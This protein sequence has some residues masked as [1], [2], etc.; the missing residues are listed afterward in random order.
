MSHGAPDARLSNYRLERLLGSGGMG[1]VYLARDLA[2][3]RDVAIKFIAADKASDTSARHRLLREAKAAASLE[4]PNICGVHEVIVEPD[5]RTAIV[6]QYVEGETLAEVL[7]RGPLEPRFAVSIAMDLAK[8]LS[9]AHKRGIIH[10]DLKPQNVIITPERQAKLLDFG[11]ARQHEIADHSAETT[12]MLTTPGVVVGTPAYMSPEQ[13][14]QLP[15]DGRSDLFA[16]GAVL[17]ECLTG[18]RPFVGRSPIDVLA[19]VLQHH[20]PTVST[21]RPELTEQHDE[22]CRRLLAKHPDDRFKSAD[23][24]FGA[25]RVLSPDTSRTG[26]STDAEREQLLSRQVKAPRTLVVAAMGALVLVAAFAVWRWGLPEISTTAEAADWY[27]RGTEAIRDGSY[28][29]GRLRLQEA[30]RLDAAYAPAYV[31]LAEAE[32]E[33]DESE[34]AVQALLKVTRLTPSDS[35]LPLDERFRFRAVRALAQRDVDEAVKAYQELVERRPRDAGAWLDLGRAQDAAALSGDARASYEKAIQIDAQYA[36][37][38][39]RRGIILALE[40]QRD[41]ALDAFAN[42]ERLYHAASSVEGEIETLIRRGGFLNGIG[43]LRDARAALERAIDLAGGTLQSRAQTIRAQLQLSSVTASEGRW[44]E[45]EKMAALAVDSALRERLDTVA[46]DGLI[47]LGNVLIHKNK[48]AEADPH[49]LRAIKIA[50]ERKAQRI[51]ARAKL[52]R[53]ALMVQVGRTNDGLATARETLDYFQANR[54]RRYE[55]QVLSI[56]ARAH[57]GLGQ[58]PEARALAERALLVSGEI[59]DEARAAE[60]LD[61]LAGQTNAMGAL[62]DALQF[63]ARALEIHTRLNDLATLPYD[64]VNRADLLIRVGRHAEGAQLLD[65]IDAGIAKKL[66]A[67]LLHG[68]RARLL[69]ALSA[70]IQHRPETS[71]RLARGFPPTEDGKAD[72]RSELAALLL[73]YSKAPPASRS[74]RLPDAPL[75]GKVL[76]TTGRE[77]RYW[78]LAARL[79]RNDVRGALTGADETL[80]SNG[81]TV[82]YEF[83]WRVAAIGAAA[84]RA[85]RDVERQRV[86]TE[87]AQRALQRLRKEWKSDVASYDARPDLVELRRKAGLD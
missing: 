81:A 85:M 20:P 74:G 86:F 19:A 38:H 35:R 11:V 70:A 5:G 56:M 7:R 84:A 41:A 31:R 61:N 67:Y 63:R 22:L 48:L 1:S 15:I 69:R 47:D 16:L 77:L 39:L 13:A 78:D 24:L 46:A 42:A 73:Q 10:R 30:I 51:V 64:L 71:S 82:S 75:A 36:A 18:R 50:G 43:E 2:L 44:T 87:R 9:A 29:T 8:A 49:L 12:T 76:L 60:A 79:M 25:L 62:P 14:Q 55:L 27:R 72:W 33:L 28:H 83:E 32:A 65:E 52:Q 21:L 59:K 40:G 45:A 34:N 68:R 80:A 58:Y 3:D 54:Y 37:A 6:M 4:H 57:E 53:A 23:E 66:D 17:Y 26:P